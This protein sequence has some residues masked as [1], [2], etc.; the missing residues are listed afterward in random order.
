MPSPGRIEKLHVTGGPGI[1]FDSHIYAGYT[2]PQYYDSMIGKLIAHGE[3][4]NSALS[5]MHTALSEMVIDGIFTNIP[6]QLE[7]VSDT[8]FN[9]GGVNIHYLEKK[10]GIHH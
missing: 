3:D 10:L 5:R 7:L 2:V 6:L 9:K 8:A 1:R 4:R